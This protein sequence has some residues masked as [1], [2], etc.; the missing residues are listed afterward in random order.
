MNDKPQ[1]QNKHPSPA[2][3]EKFINVQE[4]ELIIRGQEI[5]LRKQ[6]DGNAHEYAKAALEANVK[7]REAERTHIANITKSRYI[8]AGI[9]IFF[10]I[11]LFCFALFLNKDQIVMEIIKAIILFGSGGISGYAFGKRIPKDQ[12]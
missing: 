12:S 5:D 11:I 9:I 7:D 2:L 6:S 1:S 3:L 4:Q 8:F 10:L